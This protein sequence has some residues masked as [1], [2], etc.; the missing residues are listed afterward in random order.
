L[1]SIYM[2]RIQP[3]FPIFDEKRLMSL[4]NNRI[5]R[6]I[7]LVVCLAA[8][9]DRQAAKPHLR[10]E[11]YPTTPL[12]YQEFTGKV[13]QLV[14]ALIEEIDFSNRLLD[15][16][17]I[18]GLMA[19]YWQPLE[20]QDWD[21][22]ARLFSQAVSIVFSIGLHLEVYDKGCHIPGEN[23]ETSVAAH[24][25]RQPTRE[26]IERI[27]L[28]IFALDRMMA[29]FYGRPILLNERD[30]DRDVVK[31]AA[32][33]PPIFRLFILVV[34][35]LN[36]IQD[37]YRPSFRA[38]S[39]LQSAEVSVFERLILESGAQNAPP[40]MLATIEVFHHAVCALSVRQTRQD[41]E[42]PPTTGA[43]KPPDYP[44]LPQPLL[45]ARRSISADRILQITKQYDV[46]P[47]PFIPYAL[48]ISLSVAYRK[49]RFSQI[50]MFQARGRES[51]MEILAVLEK[52]GCVFTSARINYNL[53]QKVVEGMEK[54]H[55]NMKRKCRDK[56]PVGDRSG[57]APQ[58][59]ARSALTMMT[60]PPSVMIGTRPAAGLPVGTP[61]GAYLGNRSLPFS[62]ADQNLDTLQFGYPSSSSFPA[63]ELTGLNLFNF[64]DESGA[65]LDVGLGEMDT[66]FDRNLDPMAPAFWPAYPSLDPE[67]MEAGAQFYP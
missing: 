32:R 25:P 1:R 40:T 52:W 12:S 64:F 56:T 36:Q 33:Q 61:S 35:Q 18:L 7:K 58:S 14:R 27:F 29:S 48:S 34:W 28:C 11:G 60:N 24:T 4:G 57:C 39:S 6:A 30:F 59:G 51:F 5:D 55:D 20:E 15:Q 50:P 65:D 53:A 66:L 38:A 9:T 46:G 47:L 54:V 45:N 17:R 31:Y 8:A 16:I 62:A 21:G 43:D 13:S 49:W 2:R 42:S 63:D 67:R 19:M 3:L 23:D 44:H 37:L 22:P 41:F 26:D 10:L